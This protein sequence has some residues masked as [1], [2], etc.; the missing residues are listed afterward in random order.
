MNR[1]TILMTLVFFE[2][3]LTLVVGSISLST[4]T[5]ITQGVGEFGLSLGGMFAM[6]GFWFQMM[7]FQVESIPAVITILVFY[8]INIGI[9][10]IIA[11]MIRGN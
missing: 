6:I 3:F 10:A 4:T 11:E 7:T 9:A 8:P 5:D 1:I 2:L